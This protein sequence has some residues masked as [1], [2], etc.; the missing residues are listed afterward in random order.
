[1]Y[2]E[3]TRERE[4]AREAALAGELRAPPPEK[5]RNVFFSLKTAERQTLVKEADLGGKL[6][7]LC[8]AF[9]SKSTATEDELLARL[10]DWEK[11]AGSAL[12]SAATLREERLL[13]AKAALW[14]LFGF[15]GALPAL[16]QLSPAILNFTAP[17]EVPTSSA[18]ATTGPRQERG[19]TLHQHHEEPTTVRHGAVTRAFDEPE[20]S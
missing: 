8:A 7:D 19:R 15:D 16:K 5:V 9:E 10:N 4:K 13:S 3:K 14:R 12:V 2:S 11:S 6:L 18:A 17:K 20:P 1:M